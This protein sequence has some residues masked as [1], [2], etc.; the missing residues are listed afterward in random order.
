[1][2][3]FVSNIFDNQ[4]DLVLEDG[5]FRNKNTNSKPAVFHFNGGGKRHHLEMESK[6]WYRQPKFNTLKA[7][8]D[9]SKHAIK[10]PSEVDKD[11]TF[12]FNQIC[13]E[14]LRKIKNY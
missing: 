8:D 4:P 11:R 1:M 14:H 5:Y 6:M 7:I 9:I 3:L 2:A 10:M 13:G 12:T